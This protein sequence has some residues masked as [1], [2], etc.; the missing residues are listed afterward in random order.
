[1]LY[2][3]LNVECKPNSSFYMFKGYVNW[4]HPCVYYIPINACCHAPPLLNTLS[5]AESAFLGGFWGG[6]I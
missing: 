6:Y 2:V 4:P 1:M 5:S 3:N